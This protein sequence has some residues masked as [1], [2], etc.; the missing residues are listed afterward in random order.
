[1]EIALL[2]S[3]FALFN[4]GKRKGATFKWKCDLE[5]PSHS[6]TNYD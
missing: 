5:S 1:M 4:F 2:R 3:A 6:Y